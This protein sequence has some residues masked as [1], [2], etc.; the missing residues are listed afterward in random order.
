MTTSRAMVFLLIAIFLPGCV[1]VVQHRIANYSPGA[2]ATTQ[3]VPETAVYAVK[4]LN[5]KG[6]K[7][8]GIDGSQNFLKQ[9]DHVGFSTNDS[10]TVYAFAVNNSF[11]V[12][13]PPGHSIVWSS[14]SRRPT[15]FSKEVAKATVGTGKVIGLGIVGVAK[16]VIENTPDDED[17][18]D[19][20]LRRRSYEYLREKM[21]YGRR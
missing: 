19:A 12:E 15:Q 1:K 4:V 8:Y 20:E 5:S 17:D 3:P 7:I 13:V 9:G 21:G 16:G 2:P 11:P 18:P 6:K 14:F 10:G